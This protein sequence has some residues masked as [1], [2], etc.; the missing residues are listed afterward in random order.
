MEHPEVAYREHELANGTV[1]I[2]VYDP[3]GGIQPWFVTCI[4]PD[5]TVHWQLQFKQE[6]EA[7]EEYHRFD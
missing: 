7:L 4:N 6:A 5:D 3:Q 2:M 1:I